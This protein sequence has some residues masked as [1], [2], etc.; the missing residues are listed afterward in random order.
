MTRLAGRRRLRWTA[1]R[2]RRNRRPDLESRGGTGRGKVDLRRR[3][4]RRRR[5]TLRQVR[6]GSRHRWGLRRCFLLR[7]SWRKHRLRGR[8]RRWRLAPD[9]RRAL[10]GRRGGDRFD[11]LDLFH[12]LHV[13]ELRRRRIFEA[14]N[15]GRQLIVE[16]RVRA[17]RSSRG[18]GAIW[19]GGRRKLARRNDRT[20]SWRACLGF[21]THRDDS[22]AWH[23]K[24]H[25]LRRRGGWRTL[26]GGRLHRSG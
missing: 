2:L 20:H 17:G 23:S 24:R 21:R 16:S 22:H 10:R 19:F 18:R 15:A 12:F 9:P 8:W 4:G 26:L 3:R 7:C 5:G 11:L 13:W 14:R 25:F 1:G 6:V